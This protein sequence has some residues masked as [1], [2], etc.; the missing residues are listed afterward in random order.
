M[1]H[2]ICQFGVGEIPHKKIMRSMELFGKEAMPQFRDF[3]PDQSK[4][5]VVH[6]DEDPDFHTIGPQVA[7]PSE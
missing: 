5:P 3:V 6:L 2:L 7:S 4:Y 1:T